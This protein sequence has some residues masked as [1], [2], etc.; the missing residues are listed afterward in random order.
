MS[1]DRCV[2]IH[3]AQ[4]L[5]NTVEQCKCSCHSNSTNGFHP[6]WVNDTSTTADA[7]TFTSGVCTTDGC[8][9]NLNLN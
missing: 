6:Y 5:G 4:K 7:F 1:C 2:D 9:V 3:N 8:C